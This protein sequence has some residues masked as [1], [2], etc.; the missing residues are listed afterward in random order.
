MKYVPLLS[1]YIFFLFNGCLTH[2]QS[3]HHVKDN[4]TLFSIAK[5]YH[6]SV[7]DIKKW[8]NLRSSF[9][10]KGQSL[11]VSSPITE[12]KN[13]HIVTPKE[14]LFGIAK[15][16]DVNVDNLILWN[17]LPKNNPTI[18]PTQVLYI[19]PPKPTINKQIQEKT[20]IIHKIKPQETLFS[21]SQIYHV[22]ITDIK[23]WNDIHSNVIY[24]GKKLRIAVFQT[25]PPSKQISAPKESYN[26]FY[27]HTVQSTD[28]EKKLID[29]SQMNEEESET[30]HSTKNT[31]PLTDGENITII[32]PPNIKK[33][34]PYFIHTMNNSSRQTQKIN[35][36][37]YHPD[38]RGIATTTG[39]LYNPTLLT[40]AHSHLPL[41]KTYYI[42]NP[43]SNIGLLVRINDR[44]PQKG[45]KL[46]H[47]AYMLLELGEHN[48]QIHIYSL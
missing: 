16:Y 30:L 31:P 9:I 22:D 6:I 15:K 3:I 20:L 12:E 29:H 5:K 13:T 32:T 45:I 38:E 44:T 18:K 23:K 33:N 27:P 39:E 21:I 17:R 46:S 11:W 10:K 7:D 14:T 42:K 36:F 8:N 48:N 43:Y 25:P 19:K 28:T 24:P 40:A 1:I 4:E 47:K 34:N 41:G 2:A 37:V 26:V 35:A